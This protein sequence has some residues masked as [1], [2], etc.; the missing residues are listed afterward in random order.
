MGLRTDQALA[1]LFQG[2]HHPPGGQ[3]PLDGDEAL[4]VGKG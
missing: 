2:S 3:H 4:E 1:V